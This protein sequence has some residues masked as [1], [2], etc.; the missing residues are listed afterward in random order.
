MTVAYD[1]TA[2]MIEHEPR[3]A[4]ADDLV[5]AEVAADPTWDM[6]WPFDWTREESVRAALEAA[7]LRNALGAL[8]D[9]DEVGRTPSQNTYGDVPTWRLTDGTLVQV[10]V[11][12]QPMDG[13]WWIIL[14]D[15]AATP[16][17]QGGGTRAMEALRRY[18]DEHNFGLYV[19]KAT[20]DWYSRFPWLVIERPFMHGSAANFYRYAPWQS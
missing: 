11:S 7:A 1:G 13:G 5:A 14:D 18:A 8:L 9:A 4:V 19:Y 17:E 10:G 12:M 3:F 20:T 16:P 2:T 6:E 15:V